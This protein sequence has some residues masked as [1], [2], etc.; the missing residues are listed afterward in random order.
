MLSV[1]FRKEFRKDSR[2]TFKL[3]VTFTLERG[4][5]VLFGPSGSGKTTILRAIAGL[6]TPDAGKISL[7]DR[8]YFDSST[9][10]NIPVQ[11]RRTGLVFQDS[12][13]FPHLTAEQNVRYGM[14]AGSEL[15]KRKRAREL[16]GMLGIGYA[17]ERNPR[18]LSGGEQQ[19]VAL[20]RALA[21]E[22]AVML[23]DEPLSAVDVATRSRLLQEIVEVQRRWQIPFLHVTHSPAEAVRAG[24]WVLVLDQG[25]IVQ[26][27][28]PLEIFNSPKSLTLARVL[29]TEN[30][31]AGNILSQSE[32]DGI[33]VVDLKALRLNVSYNGLRPG[34]QATLGIRAE[35]IIVSLEPVLHTSA[36]NLLQGVVKARL[37]GGNKVEL[38]VDCGLDFKVSVTRKAV[39]DLQ[40]KPGAAVWL[41]IK[42][43][44]CHTLA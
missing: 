16:L 7:G 1:D 39:E 37:P 15:E 29:G 36:R 13:L 12:L 23:L 25:E 31:F 19:R 4:L 14:K 20:A 17:R 33:S 42:A 21:S 11:L 2:L 5:T 41:L 9:G 35:D 40:L 27:G 26:E 44:A 28:L 43:S 24:D 32:E 3:D 10:Q 38:V 34:T 6:A 18:E 22:P 8:V 30:I